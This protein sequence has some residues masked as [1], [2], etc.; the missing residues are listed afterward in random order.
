M[1]TLLEIAR[2]LEIKV[3]DKNNIITNSVCFVEFI[4]SIEKEFQVEITPA[5]VHQVDFRNLDSIV[6]FLETRHVAK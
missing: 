5:L 3:G 4:M 1:N 2:K 6:R